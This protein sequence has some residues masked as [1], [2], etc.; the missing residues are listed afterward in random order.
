MKNLFVAWFNQGLTKGTTWFTSEIYIMQLD[1]IKY[2]Q[3]Y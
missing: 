2:D 1:I 3:I